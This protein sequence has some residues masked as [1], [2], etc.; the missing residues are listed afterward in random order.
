MRITAAAMV[1]AVLLVTAALADKGGDGKGGKKV[2]EVRV[3]TSGGQA[4]LIK[5]LPITRRQGGTPRTAITLRPGGLPRFR[6]GDRLDLSSEVQVTL[7]CNEREPRCIGPPYNYDPR[8]R[9]RLMLNDSPK[10][11]GVVVGKPQIDV[12]RQRRPREHHCV[13]TILRATKNI[14]ELRKLPCRPDRCYANLVLDASHRA[15][16]PND[17]LIVGGVKPNGAIPQD[18]GR[19]NSV[20]FRPAKARYPKP[21]RTHTRRIRSIPLD[22]QRHVVYSQRLSKVQPGDSIVARANAFT[23]EAGLPFSV[24]TS[25]Q[26]ILA[27]SPTAVRPGPIARRVGGKGE[28]TESNGFNC[29]RNRE[30]C[31]TRKVGVL[32]A[33]R[34]SKLG[35]E[36][37]P[38]YVNLVMIA[39]AK[40]VDPGNRTYPVVARGGLSVTRF[41]R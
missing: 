32:R 40:R 23:R 3:A 6:A 38:L 19:V 16:D 10:P 7:N 27:E 21:E 11:G 9:A 12:C 22:L 8:V 35:G 29:T 25:A 37:Q 34:S 36:Y 26:L 2:G 33:R 39:G 15:A 30:V 31:V 41:T 5:L 1:L 17:Y 24:R 4:E 18:R 13:I 28:I 14:R 20:L